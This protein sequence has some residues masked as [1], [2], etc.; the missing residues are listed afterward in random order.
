MATNHNGNRGGQPAAEPSPFAGLNFDLSV[1]DELVAA[2]KSYLA[3]LR[4]AGFGQHYSIFDDDSREECARWLAGVFV[5]VI[6][7]ALTEAQAA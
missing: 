4:C 7:H 3:D 5:G 1:N 6:E 2:T